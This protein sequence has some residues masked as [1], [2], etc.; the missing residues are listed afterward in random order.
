MGGGCSYGIGWR[1]GCISRSQSKKGN[2]VFTLYGGEI[3]HF[4]FLRLS[5]KVACNVSPKREKLVGWKERW[6]GERK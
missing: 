6:T 4:C 3:R 2:Y 5:V 1:R